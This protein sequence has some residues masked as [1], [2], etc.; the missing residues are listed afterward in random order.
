ES[1]AGFSSFD[2]GPPGAPSLA[3]RLTSGPDLVPRMLRGGRWYR[4]VAAGVWEPAQPSTG[5]VLAGDDGLVWERQ[6][7]ALVVEA[8]AGAR[9]PIL[10]GTRGAELSPDGLIAAAAYGTGIALL[11]PGFVELAEASDRGQPGVTPG[12]DRGQTPAG[13]ASDPASTP[14]R[15]G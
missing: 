5:A 2:P 12:S 6:S 11:T 13:S 7:G 8:G 3:D 15:A 10:T 1:R 9:A 14:L 4:R